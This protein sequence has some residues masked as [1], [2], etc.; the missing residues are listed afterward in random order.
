MM[1][2]DHPAT[3]ASPPDGREEAPTL[4]PSST[5]QPRKRR[6]SLWRLLLLLLVLAVVGAAAAIWLQSRAASESAQTAVEVAPPA[7]RLTAR[8]EVRP[9]AQARIGTLGGG[10]VHSLAVGVG[11]QVGQEQEVARIRSANGVEVLTAPWRGTIT[12]IP[13][14]VGDTV[15]PGTIVATIGDLSRLDVETTDVDEFL[16]A[17]VQPGQLVRVTVDALDGRALDGSV[18]TVSLQQQTTEDGDEHYPV[19]IDLVGSASAGNLRPGM[20]VRVDFAP[21]ESPV[22]R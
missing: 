7:S 6:R 18:R 2:T 19:T 22:P 9:I 14:H 21:S 11:Q 3:P 12:G 5:P 16:I 10:I 17:H 20:T 1:R 15:M 4:P 8:G 13:V